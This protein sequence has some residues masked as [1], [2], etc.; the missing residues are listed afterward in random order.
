MLA[1]QTILFDR[2]QWRLDQAEGWLADNGYSSAKVD[3]TP[4]FLRFRQKN[5]NRDAV[6][7]TRAGGPGIRV[8]Y[9]AEPTGFGAAG[10]SLTPN[11]AD[12]EPDDMD[13]HT[14]SGGAAADSRPRLDDR[15]PGNR[16]TDDQELA[17]W[18]HKHIPGFLGVMSRT[19]FTRAYPP[20]EP[21]KPGTS[22]ILN[23]DPGYAHGGTHWVGVRVAESQPLVLYSDS[24]GMPPPREVT[25]RGRQDGRGLLYP[26]VQYQA[27]QEV[28]CGPR[29]LA[30]LKLMADG[31]KKG[32]ELEAFGQLGGLD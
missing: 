18:G 32:R 3:I 19:D 11:S 16:L 17:A 28:N 22:V 24:F 25:L 26:D 27:M 31:A 2:R 13:E 30:A 12:A 23:L 10:G 15:I 21:M 7:T 6:Y 9:M 20:D 29:A 5:P 4:N 8:V 1:V 14:A